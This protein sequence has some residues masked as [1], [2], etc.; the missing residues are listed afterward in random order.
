MTKLLLAACSLALLLAPA[1]AGAQ[2]CA[3][4]LV[5][6]PTFSSGFN[7]GSMPIGTADNWSVLTQSPQTQTDGCGDAAALQMWGNQV[8]GESVQQQLPGAGIQAGKTYRVTVCYRWLYDSTKGPD[9]VRLRLS[10]S[11]AAPTGYPPV[12]GDPVIGITPN[13]SSAS[14]ATYTFPDWTAPSNGAY[15]MLNPENDETVDDGYLTSWV[16][17]DNVCIEEVQA[18]PTETLSWSLLKSRYGASR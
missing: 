4:N 12:T 15:L 1:A 6:N 14:W 5:A 17:V 8:V 9:Y 3:S 13:T 7:P 16:R 10:M 18:V 11:A 2:T